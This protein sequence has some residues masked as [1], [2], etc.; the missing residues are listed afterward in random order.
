MKIKVVENYEEMSK[1]AAKILADAV[2]NTA[3]P[4]L[5]LATGS[6]P[7]GVYRELIGMYRDGEVSFKNVTTANLDEYVGLGAENPQSYV[8]FMKSNLFD[9]I[10]I[11]PSNTY[12]PDGKAND[13]QSECERYTKLLGNI[14]RTVQLLGLGSNGHIGFNEPGTPFARHTHIA[15]L[16]QNTVSDNSRFFGS[17]DEVPRRAITMG[18][19]DIINAETVLLLASGKNKARAA[20]DMIKGEVSEE[21]PASILQRH[22]NAVIILDKEAARLL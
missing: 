13:V 22:K 6:T 3:N 11:D 14:P 10:D 21:C 4:V 2:K 5:G 15:E 16:T 20:Y 12:I 17:I 19:A 1:E 18:I 8:S 9:Y 7:V